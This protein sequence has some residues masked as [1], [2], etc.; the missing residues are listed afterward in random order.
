MF[1]DMILDCREHK[2]IKIF[3][4]T[5]TKQLDIGDILYV[6][7]ENHSEIKLI[8]E[9]KTLNDLSSSIVDGRYKEQKCRLLSSGIRIIYILEG[10]TKNKHGV[11]FS[12]LLS[13]MLNIQLRD[14]ITV[15]RTKDIDETAN[16]L[17]M[18]KEKIKNISV[19]KPQQI[20]YESTVNISKKHN[21]SKP[22]V[23]M[24]QLSC[25]PGVSNKIAKDISES[26][27][28]LKLLILKYS[29]IESQR[30]QERLLTSIDG[31]GLVT[32]KKVFDFIY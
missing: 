26:F 15:I 21:Y 20:E 32:S 8:I 6:N 22:N 28:S 30:E 24:N 12:T 19:E 4:D 31:I 14:N 1:L 27:P 23:F 2:L 11:K 10:M 5:K 25:I 7:S 17:V 16:I 3:P 13:S 9:R 29:S 18:L